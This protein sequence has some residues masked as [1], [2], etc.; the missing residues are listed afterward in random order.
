ME[1]NENIKGKK[2]FTPITKTPPTVWG[3]WRRVF[4]STIHT[5]FTL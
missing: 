5:I 3:G 4:D 2:Q 1:K